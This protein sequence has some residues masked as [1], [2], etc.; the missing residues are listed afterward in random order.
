MKSS[1]LIVEG[2]SDVFFFDALLRVWKISGVAVSPPASVQR[3]NGK[4]HAIETLPIYVKQLLDQSIDRLAII[5][6]SDT[7]LTNQVRGVQATLSAVDRKLNEFEFSRSEVPGG[8]FVYF[9]RKN[10]NAAKIYLWLM[11]DCKQD[12]S[13]EHFVATQVSGNAIQADWYQKAEST[14]DSIINPLF[15]PTAHRMKA[16]TSTWLAWQRYPGKGMQ[17]VVGDGLIDLDGGMAA[18]LRAWLTQ[19]FK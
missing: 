17:S 12:G 6:D 5:L 7:P 3:V 13:L 10:S 14:V 16:V 18:S 19:A 15:D 1:V 8:G 4:F 11:P 2:N 9:S